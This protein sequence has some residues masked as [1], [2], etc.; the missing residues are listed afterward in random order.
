MQLYVAKLRLTYPHK[1]KRQRR[2]ELEAK[3]NQQ[4]EIRKKIEPLEKELQELLEAPEDGKKRKGD[5]SQIQAKI[6]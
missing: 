3:V 6:Q 1:S 4:R 5:P 2:A